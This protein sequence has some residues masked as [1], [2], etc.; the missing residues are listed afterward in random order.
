MQRNKQNVKN[1]LVE[2]DYWRTSTKGALSEAGFNR[3]RVIVMSDSMHEAERQ[4][5]TTL[6]EVT[7]KYVTEDLN[8]GLKVCE[9]HLNIHEK[10]TKLME[11]REK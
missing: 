4:R 1:A 2:A 3:T 5:M 6:M 11:A 8:A 10:Y 7:P 9:E